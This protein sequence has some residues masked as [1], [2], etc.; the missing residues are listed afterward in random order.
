[1]H[2]NLRP[3]ARPR[4]WV[5]WLAVVLAASLTILELAH[6]TEWLAALP[7]NGHFQQTIRVASS[8]AGILAIVV[9]GLLWIVAL[10]ISP[11]RP[12]PAEDAPRPSGVPPRAAYRPARSI[13]WKSRVTGARL[14][15]QHLF[16]T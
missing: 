9:G 1:M 4:T 2:L 10:G 13:D 11:E 7:S 15:S 3:F 16:T 6:L 5:G 14:D 12:R 8:P